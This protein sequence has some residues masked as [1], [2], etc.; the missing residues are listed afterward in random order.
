[1]TEIM[2]LN[3]AVEKPR[4]LCRA[5]MRFGF[6]NK[7]LALWECPIDGMLLLINKDDTRQRIYYRPILKQNLEGVHEKY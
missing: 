3:K 5:E 4:C 2:T 6:D 7:V 1:M